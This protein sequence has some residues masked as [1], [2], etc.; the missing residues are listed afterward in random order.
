M[1][2]GKAG[3]AEGQLKGL[4]LAKLGIGAITVGVVAGFVG[5]ATAERMIR[6]GS[7]KTMGPGRQVT[8]SIETLTLR[9][10]AAAEDGRLLHAIAL[11]RLASN[12]LCPSGEG[13][14]V[15]ENLL[16]Q[17]FLDVDSFGPLERS[18]LVG[19]AD[20]LHE[21]AVRVT[22]DG[23][24]M[25]L[26]ELECTLLQRVATG[27]ES[28]G[29]AMGRVG[30]VPSRFSAIDLETIA[31]LFRS[32][33]VSTKGG[34]APLQFVDFATKASDVLPV[35]RLLDAAT[36]Q[37]AD[38][39]E[40]ADKVIEAVAEHRLLDRLETVERLEWLQRFIFV[41]EN[42]YISIS[43]PDTI[44]TLIEARNTANASFAEIADGEIDRM[45]TAMHSLAL[46]VNN[47]A[48]PE[49]GLAL[50]EQAEILW[51]D[52]VLFDV[53][54][55]LTEST[56]SV[57]SEQ[58]TRCGEAATALA[59]A[60]ILSTN[61]ALDE[62]NKQLSQIEL[63]SRSPRNITLSDDGTRGSAA[64][65]VFKLD[66]IGNIV[67]SLPL[68]DL[69]FLDR[70][71]AEQQ[72]ENLRERLLAMFELA[73]EAQQLRYE[74]WALSQIR[75]SGDSDDWPERLG[76]I[77]HALLSPATSALWSLTLNDRLART[78]DPAQ[79]YAYIRRHLH[80][81]KVNPDRM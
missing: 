75:A 41:I 73:A 7:M 40:Q 31:E 60:I 2:N 22:V 64:E 13:F 72:L 67:F 78:P 21:A 59:S 57:T 17:R 27:T 6:G 51:L 16:R 37:L 43:S 20:A 62:L 56:L 46:Q 69:P 24:R 36:S 77:K 38:W 28:Q 45:S 29:L 47:A 42:A 68:T 80:A 61:L 30:S 23:I 10:A 3:S 81:A 26:V 1:I 74:L 66:R 79:R 76:S 70:D 12:A 32:A 11:A 35:Q 15:L 44:Q 19:L 54:V 58:A 65:V 34:N 33:L 9:S 4:W 39:P 55:T 71:S 8:T 18:R 48:T 5:A 53:G 52:S 25:R 63:E 50:A 14:A 49:A